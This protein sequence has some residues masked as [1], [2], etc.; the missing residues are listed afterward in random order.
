MDV[1]ITK[2]MPLILHVGS[3]FHTA[4]MDLKALEEEV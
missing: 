1:H 3:L 2:L 4:I